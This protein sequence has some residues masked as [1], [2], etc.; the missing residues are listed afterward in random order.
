MDELEEG[1]EAASSPSEKPANGAEEPSE[2]APADGTTDEAKKKAKAR[3]HSG[4]APSTTAAVA[5]TLT[6][7]EL[8]ALPSAKRRKSLKTRGAPGP[9]RGWRK[10]LSK[11]QKPVYRLPGSGSTADVQPG[12]EQMAVQ[13]TTPK[14]FAPKAEGGS[15]GGSKSKSKSSSGAA[16]KSTTNTS[17]FSS[18][19]MAVSPNSPDA[20][21]K[22]PTMPGPKYAP[23]VHPLPRVPNF[24]P[25]IAPLD[26]S[27]N[28]K[29]VRHW[30]M[31]PREVLNIAGRSWRVPTWLG[32]EDRGFTH[33]SAATESP[34]DDGSAAPGTP[35]EAD[36]ESGKK[37]AS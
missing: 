28:A 6:L 24:I 7:E 17:T 21:F 12:P 31:A 22:Y 30:D 26:R 14:S 13:A 11:G 27:G 19:N 20:V 36:A 5:A 2:K 15:G 35:A 33:P 3:K 23:A 1:A 34:A 9:G 29:R 18:A 32:G 16:S 10:G 4:T 25:T 37:N 8:D